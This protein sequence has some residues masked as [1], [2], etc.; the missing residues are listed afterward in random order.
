MTRVRP[1]ALVKASEKPPAPAIPM[2]QGGDE[3]NGSDAGGISKDIRFRGVRKR[4]WG[5]FAAEIRDPWKKTR[6][7]LGTFD[8]AEDAARAYDTA[9]RNLRG[10]KA[11]TNFP[12][13]PYSGFHLQNPNDLIM[14][15]RLYPLPPPHH[16]PHHPHQ[17]QII[18]A[19][20]P[21]SSSMSSTVESFSGPKQQRLT[22]APV[23]SSSRRYHRSPPILPDDCRSDCDSSSSVVD[24]GDKDIA[25]S[26]FRKSL[27][28]DLN[29][30]PPV[31]DDNLC[32]TAL[33][34]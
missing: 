16:H 32:I 7:W 21:A 6:V 29:L 18:I 5:R 19:Q 1:T 22:V 24:D 28:F 13:P 12:F 4:P 23:P 8:S 20:R 17:R 15:N 27:P 10:A 25:C 14:E 26:S 33:R 2:V 31:D 30:P 3:I 11:K 9:A 34:L